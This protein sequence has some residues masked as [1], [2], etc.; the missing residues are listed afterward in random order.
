MSQ[1]SRLHIKQPK[2]VG[3]DK[4]FCYFLLSFLQ[5][6]KKHFSHLQYPW[7]GSVAYE[8]TRDEVGG[9]T[10]RCGYRSA[11]ESLEVLAS[12]LGNHQQ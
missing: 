9:L 12:T 2:A 1:L 7:L 5:R 3:L 10:I 8:I 6:L 11:V 4:S